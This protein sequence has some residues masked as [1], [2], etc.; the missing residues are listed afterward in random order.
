MT[1]LP[2]I[3]ANSLHHNS[4]VK[5]FNILEKI[6]GYNTNNLSLCFVP[7]TG[8]V[9]LTFSNH[10]NRHFFIFDESKKYDESFEKIRRISDHS[11]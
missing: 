4:T 11:W 10:T 6:N 2:K 5:P 9:T 7:D 1:Q 3:S 8:L